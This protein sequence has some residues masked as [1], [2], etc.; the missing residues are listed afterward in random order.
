[1]LVACAPHIEVD[2]SAEWEA[3]EYPEAD[4]KILVGKNYIR[5]PSAGHGSTQIKVY[6]VVDE[7]G[8]TIR[9]ST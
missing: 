2:V 1:M 5:H 9:I 3:L 4:P 6:L 7:K 8:N